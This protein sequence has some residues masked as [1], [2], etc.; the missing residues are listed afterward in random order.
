LPHG[1]TNGLLQ[2]LG[3]V[4]GELLVDVDD[5]ALVDLADELVVA[6]EDLDI[7]VG[8]KGGAALCHVLLHDGAAG[9]RVVHGLEV[10]VNGLR[11]DL[12]AKPLLDDGVRGVQAGDDGPADIVPRL[13]HGGVVDKVQVIALG[14]Y[15]GV[16]QLVGHQDTLAER[17]ADVGVHHRD[18]TSLGDLV[19]LLDPLPLP[20]G[21]LPATVGVVMGA[22]LRRGLLELLLHRIQE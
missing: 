22:Y 11:S 19:R 6:R 3:L 15:V 14:V 16:G 5:E 2:L 9:H 4:L 7:A 20:L 10:V 1:L 12:L 13:L 18:A 21:L 8:G 17:N